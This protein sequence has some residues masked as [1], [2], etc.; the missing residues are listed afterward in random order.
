MIILINNFLLKK[1]YN[2]LCKIS[3]IPLFTAITY[4][5]V[6]FTISNEIIWIIYGK[7][8]AD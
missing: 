6:I 8:L 5:I 7:Q 1:N 2:E 4:N 3:V